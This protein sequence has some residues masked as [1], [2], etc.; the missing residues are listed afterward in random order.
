MKKSTTNQVTYGKA[1]L[2]AA[3][4]GLALVAT[5]GITSVASTPSPALASDVQAGSTQAVQRTIQVSASDSVKV[6]PD[7]AELSLTICPQGATAQEA[8]AQA[9]SELDA[10][11]AALAALGIDEK[12]IVASQV[13]IY[14]RY[15]WSDYVEK[16]VGYQASIDI[17]LRE[18]TIDQANSAIPA[19][20]GIEDT[21]LDG[22][23]FYVST[24]DERYQEAL[25][26]A[27]QVV[28]AKAQVLA[29]AAGAQ[30]GAVA[31]VC[32]N[33]D[34]QEYRYST[35]QA[36]SEA[37]TMAVAEAAAAD[38]GAGNS[39]NMLNPGEIEIKASISVTY[40]LMS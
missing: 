20:A 2:G 1:A 35:V 16:I 40:E 23:R 4:A 37:D 33:Y 10:L 17:T 34:S 18:L 24:Y 12:N 13:N 22:T 5:M 15:D 11:K 3:L 26:S 32:E 38:A 21:T 28:Q 27:L 6:S 7:M 19:I 30:L 39:S 8:Q 31:N 14:A 25:V 36:K 29:Q 9:A